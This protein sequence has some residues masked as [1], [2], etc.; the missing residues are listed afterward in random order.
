MCN[1]K[2]YNRKT[3]QNTTFYES[4]VRNPMYNINRVVDNKAV[5]ATRRYKNGYLMSY[6]W[7]KL[8]N[9]YL[10]LIS[11]LENNGEINTVIL[12]CSPMPGENNNGGGS[13]DEGNE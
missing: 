10:A 1:K 11:L 8:G 5:K 13:T 12:V 3:N 9:H 6:V 2:E 4:K 7:T